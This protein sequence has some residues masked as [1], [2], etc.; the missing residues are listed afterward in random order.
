[1]AASSTAATLV[2]SCSTF[3]L[4][5]A[6]A[7]R[8]GAALRLAARS[9]SADV[10]GL[11]AFLP[12]RHFERHALAFLQGAE[13]RAGDRTEVN[14]HVRAILAADESKT[15][16]IVEPFHSTDLTISHG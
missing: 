13:T 6:S 9:S 8:Y 12:L 14:K 2:P 4:S 7:G 5:I 1:M 3:H 15:L 10:L 16:C 11:Q